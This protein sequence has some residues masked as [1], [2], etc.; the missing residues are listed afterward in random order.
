LKLSNKAFLIDSKDIHRTLRLTVLSENK[1]AAAVKKIGIELL[2]LVKYVFANKGELEEVVLL[3]ANSVI[4]QIDKELNGLEKKLGSSFMNIMNQAI[5]QSYQSAGQA[6]TQQISRITPQQRFTLTSKDKRMIKM[7]KDTDFSLVKTLS[8]SHIAETRAI[9]VQGMQD[10]LSQ[11]AMIRQVMKRVR[12][13]EYQARRIIRTEITRTANISARKRYLEAGIKYWQWNTAIDERVCKECAPLHGKVAKIGESF[14]IRK[15]KSMTQPPLHP[16]CRCG[17][18]PAFNKPFKP[19][20]VAPKPKKPITKYKGFVDNDLAIVKKIVG[21]IPDEI[22]QK[23]KVL[24]GTHPI[25]KVKGR[26]FD[27]KEVRAIIPAATLTKYKSA[28]GFYISGSINKV[29]LSSV[30]TNKQLIHEIGHAIYDEYFSSNKRGKW[31]FMHQL[32]TMSGDFIT[33][34][35]SVNP[36]EHFADALRTFI[37]NPEVLKTKFPELYDFILENVF[38]GKEF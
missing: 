37:L 3:S 5:Q 15:G 1:A 19:K 33:P 30:A 13:T 7:L 26:L 24:N 28:T 10:G 8:S 20:K 9:F 17:V 21:L 22:K 31:I 18:S 32:H 23:V 2:K 12:N 11:T 27:D 14:T 29:F 6:A 16:F 38:F 36:D 35:A 4:A 25:V 34:R